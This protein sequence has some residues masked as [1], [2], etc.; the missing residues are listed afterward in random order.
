MNID[1]G[2]ISRKS[3]LRF[4]SIG[5]NNFRLI[6][7]NS[8]TM[9]REYAASPDEY[10]KLLMN[11]DHLGLCAA[12]NAGHP[13]VSASAG[14]R[15]YSSQTHPPSPASGTKSKNSRELAQRPSHARPGLEH[16]LPEQ[17]ELK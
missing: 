13:I 12:T 8:L 1:P 16:G 5:G 7:S 14:E 6:V 15:P 10:A 9:A 4:G 17:A 11:R 3:Q 2:K